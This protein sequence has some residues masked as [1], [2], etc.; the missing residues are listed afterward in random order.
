MVNKITNI[1]IQKTVSVRE[2][3]AGEGEGVVVR[4]STLDRKARKASLRRRRGPAEPAGEV[5]AMS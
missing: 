5:G 1:H 3:E 2:T 4:D